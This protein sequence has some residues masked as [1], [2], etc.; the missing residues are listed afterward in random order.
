V[1]KFSVGTQIVEAAR[2][3]VRACSEGVSVGEGGDGVD[4]GFVT[5]EGV[6]ALARLDVPNLGG[7]VASTRDED[8]LVWGDGARHDVTLVALVFTTVFGDLCACLDIPKDACHVSRGGNDLLLVE[9]STARK[10]TGVSAELSADS[11]WE[12][13]ASKV[14]DGTNVVETTTGNEATGGRE[15]TSHDPG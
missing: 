3:I 6:S 14:V 1:K 12:L 9:E 5:S 15:R 11:D 13:S 4:V 10:E 7:G 8:V 2:S